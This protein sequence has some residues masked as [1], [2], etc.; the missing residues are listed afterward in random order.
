MSEFGELKLL[1]TLP[2]PRG[3]NE[4]TIRHGEP[5]EYGAN[6]VPLS[7]DG[8]Y[9]SWLVGR[10]CA[11]VDYPDSITML[12][13]VEYFEGWPAIYSPF[14]GQEALRGLLEE[15]MPEAPILAL[16][17][18]ISGHGL[19]EFEAHRLADNASHIDRVV[20]MIHSQRPRTNETMRAYNILKA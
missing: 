5:K 13:S 14:E 20:L 9:M 18:A 15:R 6:E 1:E 19:L 11:A 12:P 4:H 8:M 3:V 2:R 16:E 17:P 10:D 7:D